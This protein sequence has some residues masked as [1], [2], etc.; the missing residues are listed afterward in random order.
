MIGAYKKTSF[1]R[2]T[3]T[4]LQINNTNLTK[5][6]KPL[7]IS[8]VNFNYMGF[9]FWKDITFSSFNEWSNDFYNHGC[10]ADLVFKQQDD[11][12][13]SRTPIFC[14]LGQVCV[15]SS[16][17]GFL[18]SVTLGKFC[19]QSSVLGFLFSVTRGKF[20]FNPVFYNSYFLLPGARLCLWFHTFL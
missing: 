14:Y 15:Q 9:L 8:N 1:H 17:L 13:C 2:N 4:K 18:F 12:Q 7:L 3:T 19:V 20:V 16:V 10:K 6:V 5:A 11:N